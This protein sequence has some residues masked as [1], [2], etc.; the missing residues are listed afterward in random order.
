MKKLKIE[1]FSIAA[2][3]LILMGTVAMVAPAVGG[4]TPPWTIPTW[5]YIASTNNPIGVNQPLGLLFW[6]NVPPPTASGTYGDRWIFYVDVTKPDG[7]KQVLGPYNS[8]PVGSYW[9]S[10]T[11][12]STGQYTFVARFDGQKITGLPTDPYLSA[13]A[14][15]GAASVNDTYLG[16]K[17]NPI[18]VTVQQQQIESWQEPPLPS[19]YW[20]VPINAANRNWYVLAGNWLAGAA[21]VSGPTDRFGY[22]LAPESA[23]I[24]WATPMWAGGIMDARF[25]QIGYQTGHYEGLNFVPPIILNGKIFYNVQTLPIE[26]WYCLDL[27]TGE[28]LFFH[29][30]TGPVTGVGSS[31][32]G[33]IPGE[34]LA[35]GQ[36]LNYD[37]PNQ[38]GG[39]PYLWS[40]TDPYDRSTWRMYDGVTGNYICSIA[41][42]SASGTAIYG[43][44]GSILRYSIVGS[45]SNKRLTIWNTTQAI[46]WKP[47]WPSNEYWM[48]RPGLNVTYD[49][50]NGF[51]L[52][53]SIPNVQ[54]SIL[55]VREGQYVIG[56]TSGMNRV[57]E[58]LVLGNI[59]ALSLKTG[60][61]GRL[62]YNYSYTPPYDV[63]PSTVPVSMYRGHVYG[64]SVDPED[65]VFTFVNSMT[66]QR[67]G[68]NLADGKPLW[69]PTDPVQGWQF[70]GMYQSYY[71][72]MLLDYGYSGQLIAYNV[73]TGK[74]LWIYNASQVGFESPYGNFPIHVAVIADG[75]I[76]MV[77][78]EHSESQ[79]LWRGSYIRCI[80]ATDGSE[81]WKIL[82]WGAGATGGHLT[83]TFVVLAEGYLVGLNYYDNRIYCYGKGPTTTTVST[84]ENVVARG[85]P[86]LIK[87]TIL[88]QSPGAK[89]TPAMSDADQQVWMEY[90]YMQ[91]AFPNNAKGVP[92]HLT[93]ID[94]NGNYQ[95]IG[96]A[97]S[98][99]GG[100]FAITWTP[101][102]EGIYQITASFEGSK[103]YG[104]SYG[105]S[106]LAVG[107]ATSPA[108]VVTPN[109]TP[110]PTQPVT[111]LPTLPP[112][113]APTSEPTPSP[114]IVPPTSA[115][116]ATTYIAV[117]LAV[118]VAVVAVAALVLRRR[119]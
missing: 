114:V 72:G 7:T 14:Q 118:V 29:N 103:S 106:H 49:G 73:T 9:A 60:E 36:I 26:G 102:V 32:S 62:L 40:T 21:Q 27:Y 97:V 5:I 112:T 61:E 87:G 19:Q 68:F 117:G 25:G 53:V 4:H 52:N 109:P 18:Y 116:P 17:S 59:W 104:S 45:G 100:S 85:T 42:V 39:M 91:Q 38:H 90:L 54:G 23:H 63:V 13:A 79:P 48:W 96:T 78:G 92:V 74:V 86:V 55:A 113:I 99:N 76:Y 8:D 83:T 43:K 57:N 119:K 66:L 88:D 46:W 81:I 3:L 111:P 64:P 67:W 1:V 22:G 34:S 47:S 31:S 58:T 35:F 108:V 77:S 12:T 28:T 24:L 56:G 70:Y 84:P 115:V 71:R 95:E 2:V 94:P 50:R 20:T 80:N 6:L 37:S 10:F 82:H 75:K 110:S 44:D 101:P 65:G 98:D 105:T 51:S 93:A 41:N 33:S 16:S 30:T 15:T 69:G 107:A 11:P 89:G